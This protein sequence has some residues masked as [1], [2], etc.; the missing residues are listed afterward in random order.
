[1]AARPLLP[2]A[3]SASGLARKCREFRQKLVS[4]LDHD[5]APGCLQ[6]LTGFQKIIHVR[7]VKNRFA[8]GSRFQYVLPPQR[9]QAT[10]TK[11]QVPQ[12]IEVKKL[13][14]LRPPELWQSFFFRSHSPVN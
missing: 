3:F 14:P 11:N 5:P 4:V 12:T 10:S 9:H 13:A 8:P 2:M 7:T 6:Q 1:M